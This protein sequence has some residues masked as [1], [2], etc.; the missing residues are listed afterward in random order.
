MHEISEE[1]NDELKAKLVNFFTVEEMGIRCDPQRITCMCRGCSGSN[2]INLKEER[3]LASTEKGLT[4]KKK[5]LWTVCY[6][7]IKDPKELRIM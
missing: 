5:Q 3:E 6:P 7:W 4:Y 2:G 1:Y